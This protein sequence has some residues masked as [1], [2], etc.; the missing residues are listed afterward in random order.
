MLGTMPQTTAELRALV[1][2]AMA[3]GNT[4]EANAL[5]MLAPDVRREEDAAKAKAEEI[6]RENER[7]RQEA[8]RRNQE[9]QRA[10][11]EAIRAAE[12][13]KQEAANN[14]RGYGSRFRNWIN[15]GIGRLAGE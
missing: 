5:K 14:A 3:L 15:S 6:R 7:V 2:A 10:Q 4:A 11:Q 13:A 1:D 9:Y 8:D 12:Q